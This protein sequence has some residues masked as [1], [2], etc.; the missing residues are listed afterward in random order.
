MA[1]IVV[2]GISGRMGREITAAV[3]QTTGAHFVAGTVRQGGN[4]VGVSDNLA[5]RWTTAWRLA[6]DRGGEAVIDFTSPEASVE[7]ARICAAARRRA[8]RR[9]HRVHADA[10]RG[11]SPSCGAA[12]PDR[13]RAEHVGGRERGVPA[14]PATLARALGD[15]V[16]RGDRRDAPPDE[17]GR[18]RRAPRSSWPRWWRDALGP[19][20]RATCRLRAR[21]PDRRA[22]A[23]GDRHPDPARRRRGGRAHGL[24]LRRRRAPGAHATAPPAASSSPAARC[25]RPRGSRA[26]GA[27][28]L[29]H[30]GRAGARMKIMPL[31]TTYGRVRATAELRGDEC[32]SLIDAPWTRRRRR[33]GRIRAA[34]RGSLLAPLR[35]VEDRLRR[36]EL[37]QARRGDGQ[38]GP[39]RA[40]DLPQ[41]AHRAER[42]PGEP[43]VLPPRA[44]SAPRGGAG[45]GHRPAAARNAPEAEAAAGVFGFTCFND[46]TA[47]DIQRAR[48]ST[49]APRAST[50]SPV[51]PWIVEGCRAGDARCAAA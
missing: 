13:R 32:R 7:H 6:L 50:P 37:P 33:S 23:A 43:I 16:R 42:R 34:R 49:P 19:R 26:R 10:Q 9:H 21:R 4:A 48:C 11:A 3:H 30:A 39:R 28:P 14:W 29:R 47:R 36:A 45:A 35:G 22:A 8:G 15:D 41:A 5:L 2:T 25:G 24:L 44:R 1:R 51:G 12:D 40:A 38:A 31:S 18:A 20:P 17:E 46:V 27:G